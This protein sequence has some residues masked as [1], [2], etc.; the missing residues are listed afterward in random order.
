M[1]LHSLSSKYTKEENHPGITEACPYQGRAAADLFEG[2]TGK[3]ILLAF[4][5]RY[6]ST[7]A[8]IPENYKKT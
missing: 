6:H 4:T 2:Q 5:K 7:S 8:V 1:R 3:E